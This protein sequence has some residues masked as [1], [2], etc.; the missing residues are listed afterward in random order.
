MKKTIK[1]E[2]MQSEYTALLMENMLIDYKDL[3]NK[4][5]MASLQENVYPLYDELKDF[6][7]VKAHI[8]Y[9]ARN[10]DYS[11][12]NIVKYLKNAIERYYDFKKDNPE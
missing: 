6:E 11:G 5:I 1:E 7:N 4:E 8:S 2:T 9:V 3:Q 12:T 10:Q